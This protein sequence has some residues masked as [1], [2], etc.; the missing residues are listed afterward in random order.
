MLWCY[1]W[2]HQ[3]HMMPTL[4]SHMQRSHVGPHFSHL[5]LTNKIIHWQ[6]HQCQELLVLVQTASH[7]QE[8]HITPCFKCLLLMNKMVPLIMQYESHDSNAGTNDIT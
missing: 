5:E 7:D 1:V 2:C 4:A 3:C 6:Y 8:G